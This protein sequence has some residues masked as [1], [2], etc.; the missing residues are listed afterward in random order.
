MSDIFLKEKRFDMFQR[1]MYKN[2]MYEIL[3]HNFLIAVWYI[4]QDTMVMKY[5]KS[6]NDFFE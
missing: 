2:V 5:K 4:Q 3:L 6:R 1:N